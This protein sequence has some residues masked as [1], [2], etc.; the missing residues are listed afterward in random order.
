MIVSQMD[1]R[2][3]GGMMMKDSSEQTQDME[4]I[5]DKLNQSPLNIVF[6]NEKDSL[7]KDQRLQAQDSS[8]LLNG[9]K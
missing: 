3:A 4:Q 5:R 2:K 6:Q 7:Y 9:E 1:S 8:Q